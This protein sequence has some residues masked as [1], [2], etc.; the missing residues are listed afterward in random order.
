MGRALRI[1]GI[2]LLVLVGLGVAAGKYLLGRTPVPATSSYVLDL[3]EI[4]RLAASVP[5][6]RPLRVNHE[7]V[8]EASLPSGAVFAGQSLFTPHPMTHGAYQVVYSDGF[9][10]IDSAFDE[11]TL[12]KMSPGAVFA[13]EA[14]ATIEHAL[15][16][17]KWIVITHEHVDHLGGIARYPEP[18]RLIGRLVLTREQLTDTK[19]LDQAG[20][21]EALRRGLTPLDY[22]QYHALAPGVVLIKAPGHTPGSQMV[23]VQLASGKEILFVGDVAWHMDQIRQLWYRPRLVTDFFLGENRAQV[24]AELRTLH[25]LAAREPLQLVVS[26]D[27]DQRRDLIAAGVLGPHFEL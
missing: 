15:G 3:V 7:E 9:G 11:A 14:Y 19:W 23:Y 20:F 16:H 1:L 4:R 8:A 22:E 27:V 21:P 17:A 6:E 24:M 10:V 13:S 26:H 2:G 25:D 18:E 5:G 12:H